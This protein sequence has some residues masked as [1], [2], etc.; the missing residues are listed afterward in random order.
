MQRVVITG[1]PG[2]GKTTLLNLLKTQGYAIHKEMARALIKEQQELG[3]KIVPWQNH[4]LFGQELF[5]RQ[6]AQYHQ[7]KPKII[8]F[9]DRGIPDNLGYLRRDGLQNKALE[10]KAKEYPYY[11]KVFFTPPWKNIYAQDQERWEDFNLMLEIH[12]A[13]QEIYQFYNYQLIEVPR[14]NPQERLKFVIHHIKA[15]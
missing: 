1:A 6:V 14:T 11:K 2:T 13:L 7:A 12:E 15:I 3:S 4:N 10:E 5:K 8:N 9:Y